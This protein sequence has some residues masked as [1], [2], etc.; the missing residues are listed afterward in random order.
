MEI[1][2]KIFGKLQK[3]EEK[4]LDIESIKLEKILEENKI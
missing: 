1:Y 3:V 4:K 2:L